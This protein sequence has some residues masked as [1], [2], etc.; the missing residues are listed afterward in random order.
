[1]VKPSRF[2]IDQILDAATSAVHEHWRTA[3]VGHVT[4]RLGA[5][6]GSI[7][8]R[9]ASRDALFAS[10]WIR[11]V[12]RYHAQFDAIYEL[13][14]P[15]EAI[16]ETGLFIPRFCRANPQDARMLTVFR[17]RDLLAEPP[18]GLA[19]VL[20]ELN[21]PVG[22]LI[23]HLTEQRYGRV[24]QRGIELVSLAVRDAPLGMV[25]S[26]IGEDI[27]HWLDE[28]VQAASRAVAQLDDA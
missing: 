16:V 18:A 26:L 19:D 28:P 20:L 21:A 2:T 12:H 7:Y 11:A 5:P 17:Y 4:A 15:L 3:T 9:F 27:P 24:R 6:S 25:R 23:T 22:R 14:D 1:M 8:H 13:V 10:A